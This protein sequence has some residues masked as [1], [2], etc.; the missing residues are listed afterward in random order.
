M[1]ANDLSRFKFRFVGSGHYKVWY[2]TPVRGDYWVAFVTDM[3]LIDA[4]KN[5]EHA[6][7]ADIEHLRNVVKRIG[8][9]YSRTGKRIN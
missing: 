5:A 2:I 4:T 7:V 6:K 1:K 3:T 9:H 8:I